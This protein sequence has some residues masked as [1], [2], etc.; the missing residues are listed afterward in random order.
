MRMM[1]YHGYL[2]RIGV[3]QRGMN[4]VVYIIS[5][6]LSQLSVTFAPLRGGQ[7]SVRLAWVLATLNI[8]LIPYLA[9][10]IGRVRQ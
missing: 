4:P 9:P 10:L 1:D 8:F 7:E 3:P 2:E 6:S 5:Q